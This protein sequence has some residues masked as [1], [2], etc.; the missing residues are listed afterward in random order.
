MTQREALLSVIRTCDEYFTS[1]AKSYAE[2]KALAEQT[3]TSLAFLQLT[4]TVGE[5][6]MIAMQDVGYK[7]SRG[8][9]SE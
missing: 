7:F 3:S 5:H 6:L 4:S 1:V 9:E 8:K 2:Q